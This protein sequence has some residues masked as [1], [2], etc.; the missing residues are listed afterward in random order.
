MTTQFSY[1][2]LV[3]DQDSLNE[4]C[5]LE[6]LLGVPAKER[7]DIEACQQRVLDYP[8][9]TRN[10]MVRTLCRMHEAEERD[11]RGAPPAKEKIA[12]V[13]GYAAGIP[14][15]LHLEAYDAYSKKWAPQPAMIDLEGRNCRGGFDV[16]ELDEFI[17]GWRDRASEIGRL[18][19]RVAELEAGPTE[20][21]TPADAGIEALQ[22]AEKWEKRGVIVTIERQS[23]APLAMGNH[24]VVA[25]A[26]PKR[27]AA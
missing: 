24:Y 7:T 26:W 14:W 3:T 23:R 8:V 22:L 21:T 4:L 1:E 10:Q 17:P 15:S 9:E 19:A 18:R 12:P 27:G 13:Q 2:F 20:S 11:A 6:V 16:T 5:P 25:S